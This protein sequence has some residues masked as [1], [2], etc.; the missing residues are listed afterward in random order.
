MASDKDKNVGIRL[1]SNRNAWSIT[2]EAVAEKNKSDAD[3][4]DDIERCVER[5]PGEPEQFD[6]RLHQSAEQEVSSNP[7]HDNGSLLIDQILQHDS[8][9]LLAEQTNRRILGAAWEA[10]IH[11]I[12]KGSKAVK[13]E[14]DH[15]IEMDWD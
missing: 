3:G 8:L 6:P 13:A 7:Q 2:K 15:G 12:Q 11:E 10:P 4:D 14:P 5:D 1:L 9:Y